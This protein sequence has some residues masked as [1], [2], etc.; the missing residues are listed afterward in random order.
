MSKLNKDKRIKITTRVNIILVLVLVMVLGYA[1]RGVL[2][3]TTINKTLTTNPDLERGLVGHWT[4]DG[5]DITANEITDVTGNGGIG[6]IINIATTS[7][8]TQGKIGQGVTFGVGTDSTD[9]FRASSTLSTQ[10]LTTL[11][12]A[13]WIY[14]TTR[15]GAYFSGIVTKS[16]WFS[17]D[18]GWMLDTCDTTDCSSNDNSYRFEYDHSTMPGIWT[19]AANTVEL[20]TWTHVIVTYDGSGTPVFYLNGVSSTVSVIQ[21]PDGIITPDTIESVCISEYV[22]ISGLIGC[23]SSRGQVGVYDDVRIYNR[24]LTAAEAKRLYELGATTRIA[25][26][27]KTNPDL[28]DG[29]VGHWTFDGPDMFNNVADSSGQG[30]HGY[31]TSASTISTT[32]VP[33][34]IGQALDF[35]FGFTPNVDALSQTSLDGLTT[36]TLAAWVNPNTITDGGIITKNRLPGDSFNGWYL[37]TCVSGGGG[38]CTNDNTYIFGYS[39]DTTHGIWETDANTVDLNEWTHVSAT[40]DAS[41]HFNVPIIYLDG[42]SVNV[43]ET[44]NSTGSSI[45][46]DANHVCIATAENGGG[47]GCGGGSQFV[48]AIDDARV[49]NRILSA[50]EV[51]RLYGLGATTRINKTISTVKFNISCSARI[52]STGSTSLRC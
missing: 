4:F 43:T 15:T 7:A 1:L 36:I 32:T 24:V 28:D 22:S 51:S 3:D 30:N 5:S 27:L 42:V 14:P 6:A 49:Y 46:D 17:G 48:G 9:Y 11:S 12:V 52:Y 31:I 40:F 50:D 25:K 23:H 34:V 8:L 47:A 38:L 2:A 13:L 21:A 26:T 41:S 19:T 35:E 39:F 10:G 16:T 44:S 45:L 29:L 33:G 20:N 18:P 37:A